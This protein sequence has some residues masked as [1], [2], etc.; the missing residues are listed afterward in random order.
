[1]GYDQQEA[2]FAQ[3]YRFYEVLYFVGPTDTI[4]FRLCT[5][6]NVKR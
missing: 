5:E 4:I 1:M 2:W 3:V 6:F